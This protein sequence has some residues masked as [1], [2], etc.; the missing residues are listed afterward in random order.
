MENKS[1][2]GSLFD[3]SFSSFI[4]PKI[5]KVLFVIGLVLVLLLTLF[6]I[7]F[8]F[9][10]NIAFGVVVLILS[11]IIFLLYM[12]VVRIYLEL[13]IVIFRIQGDIAEI[14]HRPKE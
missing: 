10:S 11:P 5:I 8:A 2:L 3:F 12:L 13:L 1:F 14:A 6:Y 4:T 9:I 7:I